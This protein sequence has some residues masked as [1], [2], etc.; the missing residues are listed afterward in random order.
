MLSTNNHYKKI[1]EYYD[2]STQNWIDT[3]RRVE[4]F[5][6]SPFLKKHDEI[7]YNKIFT[8]PNGM[9]L[10]AGCGDFSLSLSFLEKNKNI[11]IHGVTLSEVQKKISNNNI[12]KTK[13]KH[14][15]SVTVQN[16]NKL[17][18]KNNYFD[19]VYFIESF[20]HSIDKEKTVDELFRIL[21]PGGLCYI[22]DLNLNSEKKYKKIID[23]NYKK[24]YNL[25]YFAPVEYGFLKQ[26]ISKKFEILYSNTGLVNYRK[27]FYKKLRQNVD[28]EKCENYYKGSNIMT[29]YG[30][31]HKG[32]ENFELPVVWSEVLLKK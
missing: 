7:L 17:S 4:S 9:V 20:S 11:F 31:S 32:Q 18:F 26:I 8:K 1:S 22:L 27:N 12:K 2:K 5:R 3:Y 19:T 28:F 29:D 23:N 10:D 14:R 24:W 30:K 16:F 13:N 15:A 21:K 25:F 6:F